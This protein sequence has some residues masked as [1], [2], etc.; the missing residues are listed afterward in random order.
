[1][2][3]VGDKF[4]LVNDNDPKPLY[5][6]FGVE[7]QGEFSWRY[8]EQRPDLWRIEIGR[9]AAKGAAAR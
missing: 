5:C 6:Q 7:H 2:V 4:V 3:G 9:I 1:M 8:L